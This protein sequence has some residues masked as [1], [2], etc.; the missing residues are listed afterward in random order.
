MANQWQRISQEE[1]FLG[2]VGLVG[3]ELGSRLVATHL[4]QDL[5]RLAFLMEKQFAPYRKWFGTAFTELDIS[6]VLTPIFNAV[7]DSQDWKTRESHL[8]EA[9]L[10]MIRQH[11][12]LGVTP[13]IK[14][15]V[16]SFHQR[17]FL[18]SQ[19]DRFVDALLAKIED[20]DVKALP[21]RLGSVDQISN[22]TDVLDEI[23]RC[24]KLRTLYDESEDEG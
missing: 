5:M 19:A 9:Y 21:P 17:P 10:L 4:I 14:A 12:A 8:C 24:K 6:S 23:K 15:E 22:N 2:R 18:V 11:N 16:S 1:A 13:T 3:D 7:L 20:L